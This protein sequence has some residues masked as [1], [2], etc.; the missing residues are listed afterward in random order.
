MIIIYTPTTNI[1]DENHLIDES[2]T[3]TIKGDDA[4]VP[5]DCAILSRWD[6]DEHTAMISK[7][8]GEMRVER[9]RLLAETDFRAL[10]DMTAMSDEMQVYRQALR[11]LPANTA[12]ISNPSYPVKPK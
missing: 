12:N 7:M 9:N 10:S 11:D 8:E 5:P 4:D 1:D 3:T 2:L 6:D